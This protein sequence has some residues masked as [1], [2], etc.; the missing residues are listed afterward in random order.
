MGRYKFMC[1]ECGEQQVISGDNVP[2][3]CPYCGASNIR[4]VTTLKQMKRVVAEKDLEKIKDLKEAV[5]NFKN[6]YQTS[7]NEYDCVLSTLRLYK[8]QNVVTPEEIE[9]YVKARREMKC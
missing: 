1:L 9:P 7:L 3:F 2:R 5:L 6:L 8:R 4:E